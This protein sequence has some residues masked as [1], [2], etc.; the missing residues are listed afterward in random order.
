[1]LGAVLE[2]LKAISNALDGYKEFWK[3]IEGIFEAVRHEKYMNL[4]DLAS[5]RK[6][7]Y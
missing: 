2:V 5:A 3:N 1:M 6:I 7:R 4:S